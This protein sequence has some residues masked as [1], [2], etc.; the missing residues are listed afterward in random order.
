MSSCSVFFYCQILKHLTS[1]HYLR[2]HNACSIY[3][4]VGKRLKCMLSHFSPVQLFAT[5]WTVG[6]QASLSLWFSRQEY[7]SGLPCPPPGDLPDPGSNPLLLHLLH[8]QAG[9]LPLAPPW[10]WASETDTSYE[11]W[12]SDSFR[13]TSVY[14]L[15]FS[16]WSL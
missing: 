7:W 1:Q 12:K 6:C 13:E 10:K 5:P 14:F 4:N 9:S 16:I 11:F 15:L 8:W 2:W 3:L